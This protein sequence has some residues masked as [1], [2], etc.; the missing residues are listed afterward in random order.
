MRSF[1]S[2]LC[3]LRVV[4]KLGLINVLTVA[5][6]RVVLRSGWMKR[7]TPVEP[8]FA[9][10]CFDA[11]ESGS[12]V[13]PG[14]ANFDQTR[15]QADQLLHGQFAYFS[16]SEQYVGSPPAWFANPFNA[17]CLHDSQR[18]WTDYGDFKTE[19]GDIKILWDLSRFGW[20][21]DFSR[22]FRMTGEIVYLETLNNWVADW[23]KNNPMNR[24][25]NWKCGQEAAIRMQHV[26]L[27][28]YLLQRAK[29]GPGLINFVEQHCRRIALTLRYALAQDNNHGTSEAA[30]LFVGG[31]WLYKHVGEA[32]IRKRA[33]R[34][35]QLGRRH[36]ESRLE[37]LVAC[38]GSFSQ[39]STVYHRM[40]LDTLNLVEFWRRELEEEKFAR[41][42]HVKVCALG[43]WLSQM[44]DP[45]TGDAP[46]LGANDGTL[47]FRLA[48][49]GY[50]DFRPSVQLAAAMFDASRVY[51][52]GP[53]DETL[54]W[55]N[56]DPPKSSGAWARRHPEEF[57]GGGYVLFA[58][59]VQRSWGVLRYPKYRFRP[60]HADAL[61]LDLWFQ[62]VNLLRDSGTYSYNSGDALQAY[63]GSTSAHN[64]V[65][66]DGRDQMP[67]LGRFLRGCWLKM[68]QIEPLRVDGSL[69]LWSGQYTDFNGGRHKRSV[70]YDRGDWRIIDHVSGCKSHATLRWRLC[71]G[72]WHLAGNRCA[73]QSAALEVFCNQPSIRSE[74]VESWESRQYWNKSVLPVWEIE[75]HAPAMTFETRITFKPGVIS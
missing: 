25:P 48:Q 7:L 17:T 70:E 60:G 23:V 16:T 57:T 50:R 21:L 10:R 43:N 69:L 45:Q 15:A 6:Y 12:L 29:P 46:N 27:A 52:E 38:D 5:A 71:P 26:L 33:D 68:D 30:A 59:D 8:G 34:W 65:E 56:I 54:C 51:P 44:T 13:V 75:V 28:A 66:L 58:C 53:W 73:G 1:D 9:G 37:R 14:L 35:R 67:R 64:T 32:D 62:G 3:W 72:P 42:F 47:L 40:V 74:I 24:G 4:L 19:I 36:L 31:A 20:A 63:F 39:N 2:L 55:L 18:H 11:A 22:A 61:H 41:K 49:T